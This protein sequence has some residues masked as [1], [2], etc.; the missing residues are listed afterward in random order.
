[1][2]IDCNLETTF[3]YSEDDMYNIIILLIELNNEKCFMKT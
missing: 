1:M 2:L 3:F